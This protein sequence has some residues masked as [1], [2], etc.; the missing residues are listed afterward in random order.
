MMELGT[1]AMIRGCTPFIKLRGPSSFHNEASVPLKV[2]L[3]LPCADEHPT[4]SRVRA[5]SM[6][7]VTSVAVIPASAPLA[8]CTLCFEMSRLARREN[9]YSL[10]RIHP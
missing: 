6:G 1:V 4:C 2:P 7:L 8:A 10:R 9:S 5:T 3:G